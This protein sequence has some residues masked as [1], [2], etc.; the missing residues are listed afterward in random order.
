MTRIWSLPQIE[1]ALASVDLVAAMERAFV[2]YSSG[3]AVVPPVGELLFDAPPGDAHIK[4]GYVREDAV[5]VVKIATGFYENP[6]RGL[7]PNSGMMLVFSATTGLPEAVLLD[8]GHLTNVRTAAAGAVAAKFLGPAEVRRIGVLGTG[9]QA[10]MQVEFLRTVTPC[11]EVVVWGRSRDSAAGYAARMCRN[12]YRMEL[13]R[14][15]A[16]VAAHCNLIVTA[17]IATSPLLTAADVRPGTHITAMGSDTP[18]KNELAPDVLRAADICVVDSLS[19]CRERGELHHALSAGAITEDKAVELGNVVSGRAPGRSDPG[20][21]TVCDLTG[22]AVQDIEISK[23][24]LEKLGQ[25]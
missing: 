18:A 17:T 4:Y 23:A 25:G 1:E 16:D 12:G 11:R 15:P 20:Q 10:R 5:F 19:Q 22:V 3:R 8:E 14:S 13:A 2:A 9:V 21:I 6:R 24:V 7:P